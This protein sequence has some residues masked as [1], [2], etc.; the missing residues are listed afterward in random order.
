MD[1][2][3]IQYLVDAY[4]ELGTDQF[5]VGLYARDQIVLYAQVSEETALKIS[6]ELAQA[7]AVTWAYPRVLSADGLT[8][9]WC[10]RYNGSVKLIGHPPGTPDQWYRD[11]AALMF[12]VVET[13]CP[14]LAREDGVGIQ[15]NRKAEANT[16]ESF[17]EHCKIIKEQ[18]EDL[19]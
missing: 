19:P 17:A 15:D 8:Y 13:A 9:C 11:V 10:V 3:P 1:E 14:E 12:G 6:T 7:S 16:V 2:N 5:Q 4:S 18:S